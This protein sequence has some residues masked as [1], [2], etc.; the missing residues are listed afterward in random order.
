MAMGKET[1]QVLI[2]QYSSVRN[3]MGNVQQEYLMHLE[4]QGYFF[5]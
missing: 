1:V 5:I 4:F 3:K 2:M